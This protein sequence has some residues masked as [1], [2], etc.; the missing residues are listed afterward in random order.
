MQE[1]DKVLFLT[2][3]EAVNSRT[4]VK[5]VS[6]VVSDTNDNIN[7]QLLVVFAREKLERQ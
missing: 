7:L 2:T 5:A 1:H 4:I 6:L 3:L